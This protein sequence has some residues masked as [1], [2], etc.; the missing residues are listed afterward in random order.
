MAL[1]DPFPNLDIFDE[2][3]TPQSLLFPYLT[4]PGAPSVHSDTHTHT[5]S[6][7]A[8]LYTPALE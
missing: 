3:L 1:T 5:Q 8:I 7:L 6:M 4:L 2:N